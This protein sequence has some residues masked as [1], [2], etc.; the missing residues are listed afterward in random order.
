MEPFPI[1][2]PTIPRS[3]G[4]RTLL[5]VGG[6]FDPV[7]SGHVL[8]PQAAMSI[9]FGMRGRILYVPAARSPHKTDGPFASD[10]HRVGML[11]ALT[12][13]SE[14]C[15]YW[16]DEIDRAKDGGGGDPS[17]TIDTLQRLRS[18][19]RATVKLRLVIGIDQALRFHTWRR[20][21]EIIEIAEPYVLPRGGV[22]QLG[23][24]M[25]RGFWT[26]GE[27][28]RWDGWVAAHPVI[29][30]DNS[31]AIRAAIPGA[32]ADVEAWRSIDG[33]KYVPDVVARY[34]IEHNLYGFRE[35]KRSPAVR[36]AGLPKSGK[37]P[38]SS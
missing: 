10:E 13:R 2:P 23:E 38:K 3:R 37:I 32:P 30:D 25:D 8:V 20:P 34:I 22:A 1:T 11:R 7:H 6:S 36:T 12:E 26:P 24:A 18:V 9:D 16:T 17:Y 35:V 33:L 28:R 27:R 29:R 31:T 15:G 4:M 14:S 21:R 5:V 19:I